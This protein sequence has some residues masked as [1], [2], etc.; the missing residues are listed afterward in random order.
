M[1]QNSIL[2]ISDL[3]HTGNLTYINSIWYAIMKMDAFLLLNLLED[4]MTYEDVSKKEFVEILSDRF[5]HHK[6][7]SDSEFFMDFDYCKGCN[8]NQPVCKFVGNVS[9]KHFGLFFEIKNDIITDI[10]TCNWYGDIDFNF[11]DTTMK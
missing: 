5:N 6:T 2:T 10:Y 3:K 11:D 7:L 8:C 9:G 1:K 4:D